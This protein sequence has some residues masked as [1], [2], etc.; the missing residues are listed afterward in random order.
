[1]CTG[2]LQYRRAWAVRLATKYGE[3]R[4]VLQMS[5]RTGQ[6]EGRQRVS[7]WVAHPVTESENESN[8]H[9]PM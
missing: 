9:S 4:E 5:L 8:G 3:Q 1:M 2:E 6:T 7:T